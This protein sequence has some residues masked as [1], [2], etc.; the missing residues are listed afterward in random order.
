MKDTASTQVHKR[1]KSKN[2][3]I[4]TE[5]LRVEVRPDVRQAIHDDAQD[6]EISMNQLLRK[7]IDMYLYGQLS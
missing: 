6:M 4:N 1:F 5:Q 7:L 3:L 2:A